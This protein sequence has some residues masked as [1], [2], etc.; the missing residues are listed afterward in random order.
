MSQYVSHRYRNTLFI[1]FCYWCGKFMIS[2][3]S[4]SSPIK[5]EV[6]R[7]LEYFTCL[8][9]TTFLLHTALFRR[10]T[11]VIHPSLLAGL[12]CLCSSS[13]SK[14][15]A[16]LLCDLWQSTKLFSKNSTYISGYTVSSR[17][18]Y[19]IF[20]ADWQPFL[21]DEVVNRNTADR[22]RFQSLHERTK[23]DLVTQDLFH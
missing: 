21:V 20:T 1:R 23:E 16:L 18:S 11:P 17:Q 8:C 14:R 4:S 10:I 13:W 15:T 19:L 22:W 3:Y 12:F 5:H 6:F 2:E 9:L 7:N